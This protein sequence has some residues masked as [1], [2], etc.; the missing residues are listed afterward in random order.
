MA[1]SPPAEAA[2]A[3]GAEALL[4]R[5]EL[6]VGRRLDGIL[7]GERRGR[8]PG[9]GGDA[10]VTRP[11]EPGDDVR[12]IDWPLT[13]RTG[14]PTVRVPE[15]EPVLTAWALVDCSPS[16]DFGSTIRTKR[17]LA[18]EALAGLGAVLRRRGDRLGVVAT[19][20]GGL[21]LVRPPRG[22]RRGLV[23]ALAAVDAVAAPAEPG[24]T[25][26][27]RA[28]HALGRVASHR[29]AVV[30]IS[31]LPA[32][33]E[34]ELAIGTLSRRHE[35]IAIEVGD[36]RERTIPDIGAVRLRDVETGA[37][38]LVDTAD[39]RF[40]ERLARV[41]AERA[42][43]RAGML[44]RAGARHIVLDTAG[45]WIMPLARGLSSPVVRRI[46]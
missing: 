42:R 34:L 18:R 12:W 43:D 20:T 1:A 17:D 41:A 33:P 27:A 37:V 16:M 38:R 45:D 2:T 36:P 26:L 29:G 31:D 10:S 22:D 28:V 5:V 11:Y 15:I 3:A 32:S 39:P 40:R 30:V 21:D 23:A 35:V 46:A 13:A 9:P 14:E 6:R 7:Q 4:R 25:D 24:R 19:T 44:A 8:R